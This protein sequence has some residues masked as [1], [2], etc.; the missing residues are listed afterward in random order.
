MTRAG[1]FQL[2]EEYLRHI[3]IVVLP[4]VDKRMPRFRK[5]IHRAGNCRSFYELWPSPHY[6][7]DVQNETSNSLE[8]AT[9]ARL[10]G[11]MKMPRFLCL[12]NSLLKCEQFCPY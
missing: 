4:G 12:R 5:I 10:P 7:D 2:V 3:L 8:F 1:D 9:T 6:A 11:R